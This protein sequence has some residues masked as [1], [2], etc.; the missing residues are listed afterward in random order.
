MFETLL[1]IPHLDLGFQFDVEKL[2][3]EVS[4]ID[5]YRSYKSLYNESKELYEKNWSGASLISL[6]G[7]IFGDME[8]LK[9]YPSI[10]PKR[11]ALADKCPYLMSILD[12]L[13]ASNER[14]RIM[15]ISPHG[16]LDWHSHVL[17]HKQNVKR[18]VV[19][20]PIYVPK[21][22][23]Y[24]VVNIN[25]FNKLKKGIEVKTHD[26]EYVPGRAYVF[27]SYH[28]HNVFN[29]SQEHRITLMTY[30]M[31]DNVKD[32]ISKAVENYDGS[33]L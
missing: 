26:M 7:S 18:L 8:E 20:V 13:Q 27:N 21:G 22:F 32:L 10:Q 29:P 2:L 6:D 9:V 12:T 31:Y 25:D 14:S 3:Q 17:H 24:S 16:Q 5:S 19:Q 33:L 30:V 28:P 4:S 1:R 15:R 11:T 23:R